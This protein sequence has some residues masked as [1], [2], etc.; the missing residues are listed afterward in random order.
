MSSCC[1]CICESLMR[2]THPRPAFVGQDIDMIIGRNIGRKRMRAA[3]SMQNIRSI[4]TSVGRVARR[5]RCVPFHARLRQPKRNLFRG[6]DAR[7]LAA[8]FSRTQGVC[9]GSVPCSVIEDPAENVHITFF[10]YSVPSWERYRQ[11]CAA[12]RRDAPRETGI[13]LRSSELS[14][15]QR[16]RRIES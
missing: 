13:P 3:C 14:I 7:K 5:P 1:P 10:C 12:P 4:A 2:C 9:Y 8:Y 15:F 11:R 6:C 16:L